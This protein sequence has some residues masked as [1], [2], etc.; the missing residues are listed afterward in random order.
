[1][2]PAPVHSS[3]ADHKQGTR[4][5]EFDQF[6]YKRA[7]HGPQDP[8]VK[9]AGQTEILRGQDSFGLERTAQRMPLKRSLNSSNRA[10]RS[11]TATNLKS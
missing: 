11:I 2:K 5:H 7:V 9:C 3:G 1:M 4:A 6:S 8:A 10:G